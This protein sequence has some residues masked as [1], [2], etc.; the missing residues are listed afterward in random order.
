[1]VAFSWGNPLKM[2]IPM[3]WQAGDNIWK[4]GELVSHQML[5]NERGIVERVKERERLKNGK[6]RFLYVLAVA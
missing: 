5:P 3:E 4:I 1:M 2:E 6:M